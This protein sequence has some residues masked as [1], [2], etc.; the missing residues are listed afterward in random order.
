[1]DAALVSV[2]DRLAGWLQERRGHTLPAIQ[3][4]A[5]SAVVAA[6]CLTAVAH[7]AARGLDTHS[8]ILVAFAP[9]LAFSVSGRW[10]SLDRDARARWTPELARKYVGLADAYRATA[11]LRV[12]ISIFAVMSLWSAAMSR[13]DGS[14]GAEAL[15][16][17]PFSLAVVV[18]LYVRCAYPRDPGTGMLF[19]NRALGTT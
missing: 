1:M 16:I 19:G 10:R 18:E 11:G 3:R 15:A 13:A 7:V 6:W 12:V 17:V 9:A 4:E 5:L 2:V 8:S 14:A